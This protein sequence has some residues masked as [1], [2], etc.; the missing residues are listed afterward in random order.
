M[1]GQQA[2]Y[3]LPDLLALFSGQGR[4]EADREKPVDDALGID[5]VD[6]REMLGSQWREEGC[7]LE[8][9][10]P[11]TREVARSRPPA[12]LDQLPAPRETDAEAT[13]PPPSLRRA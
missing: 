7:L 11:R 2:S 10:A 12:W 1:L 8:R 5:L 13:A 4:D 6:V 3:L 9:G